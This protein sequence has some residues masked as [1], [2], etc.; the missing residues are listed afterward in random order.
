MK[1]KLTGTLLALFIAL[2]ITQIAYADSVYIVQPG[3]TLSAIARG[4]D[5]V[6]WLD[7]ARANDIVNPNI[8]YVGQV[9]LIPV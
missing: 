8:I 4:Y 1:R 9:L 5:G 2:S 6:S 3:D 7:I